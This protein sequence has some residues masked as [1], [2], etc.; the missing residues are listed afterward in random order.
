[1]SSRRQFIRNTALATGGIIFANSSFAGIIPGRKPKVIIIGA[2]F[3]GLS[4]ACA[5]KKK[6]IDFIIL[7]SRNRISGRV[8]SQQIDENLVV[9]FGAEWVGNSHERV[10]NLCNGYGLELQ[11]NQFN[12]HLI[13]QGKYNRSG[14]WKLSDEWT[15]KFK[16][17]IEHYPSLTLADKKQLD[18]TD[19]WRFLVDQG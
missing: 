9:E 8:F 16:S 15:A 12:T 1:M 13:Y 10:H 19:W 5:L 14:D 6:N 7:E 18:K 17:I 4:A 11:N 2:G 3:A